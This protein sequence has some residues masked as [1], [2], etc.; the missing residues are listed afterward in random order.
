MDDPVLTPFSPFLRFVRLRQ[1]FQSQPETDSSA[2]CADLHRLGGGTH[3]E[4]F[5]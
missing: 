2:D 5:S 4:N 1:A 3:G